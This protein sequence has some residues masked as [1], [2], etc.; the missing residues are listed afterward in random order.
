MGALERIL[1]AFWAPLY[2]YKM[3][4]SRLHLRK[5]RTQRGGAMMD[6]AS[7]I[8]IVLERETIR[9]ERAKELLDAWEFYGKMEGF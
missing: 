9:N 6:L 3:S 1:E 2:D 8:H 5:A 4:S 7:I